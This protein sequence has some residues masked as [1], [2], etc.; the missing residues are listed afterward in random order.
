M[1]F[2]LYFTVCWQWHESTWWVSESSS[3]LIWQHLFQITTTRYLLMILILIFGIFQDYLLLIA[4]TATGIIA[5]F[6]HIFPLLVG[7]G[8][9]CPMSVAASHTHVNW[10][11]LIIWWRMCRFISL[12]QHSTSRISLRFMF[13]PTCEY[14][15]CIGCSIWSSIIA[16]VI[17]DD[18]IIAAL[19]LSLRLLVFLESICSIPNSELRTQLASTCSS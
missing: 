7:G 6:A 4:A 10:D 12:Q 8:P 9:S 2:K 5:N 1:T 14:L 3:L 13:T 18:N 11:L 15:D 17:N 16:V 19:H